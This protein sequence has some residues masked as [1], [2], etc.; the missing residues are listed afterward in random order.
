MK[1]GWDA[2]KKTTLADARAYVRQYAPYL[3]P[4]L[5]GL[6]PTPMEGLT[7]L[8][9]GPLAVTDRLVMYY[10]P[11]W[12]EE[13]STIVLAT[14]LA[15][16]CLHDQLRHVVRGKNYPDK[17]RWNWA[18]DLFINGSMRDQ[19]KTVN[20]GGQT[21]SEP[22]W[23]FPDWALM[24]GTPKFPFPIGL[25]ADKYYELLED[26][27]S[28]D[29]GGK[30]KDII[31][32]GSC[33][34]VAGNPLSIELETR[35]NQEKGRSESECRAIAKNTARQIQKHMEGPG[36]GTLPGAWAEL[37]QMSDDV[38]NVP[39]RSKL[40]NVARY[41]IGAAR[42]GGLD[43]SRRR[44][45]RRSYLRGFPLP[46]LI[47]Y[48]PEIL[49]IVDSSG[50]M[51]LKQLSDALRICSD[52]M[53]QTGIRRAWFMEAD[54]GKQRDPI[55]V[56]AADLRT[57]EIKGRGGTDFRPAIKFADETFKPRP[58]VTI[59][60]T[61]GDGDAPT[62]PPPNMHF[63]WCIVRSGWSKRPANWGDLIWLDDTFQG[64]EEEDDEE[65][66]A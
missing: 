63:I 55:P 10:E 54:V 2:H 51:G 47:A 62:Q 18:G 66:V 27:F 5:Y 50:S 22:L 65:D 30:G 40:G 56:T 7:E 58:H 3:A 29:V 41:A 45:S 6:I 35:L 48:D 11:K 49:Y 46:G 16:E 59:Y 61:D 12:I 37:I 42:T 21:A 36:R 15:H 52:V 9:G 53:V 26:E 28:G 34:G 43:Y 44:P 13:A 33:G 60:I 14:G 32:C 19:K 4:T 24:P 64:K 23:E 20:R 17:K 39:W 31:L 8:A 1:R 25:T 57:L 38:F